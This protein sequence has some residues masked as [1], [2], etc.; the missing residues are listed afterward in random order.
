MAK[1]K[2]TRG[3]K[4]L[5]VLAVLALAAAIVVTVILCIPKKVSKVTDA[6]RD[7]QQSMFLSN[8]D[9]K[10]KFDSFKVKLS[11]TSAQYSLEINNA[12][13]I[14]ALYSKMTSFYNEKLV[15]AEDNKTYQNNY[16]TVLDGF[17]GARKAETEMRSVLKQVSEYTGADPTFVNPAWVRFK[18]KFEV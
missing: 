13:R 4:W 12:S 3:K 16:F 18:E 2:M 1:K 17:D 11:S 8:K 10:A 14:I 15:F 5:I 7:M 6:T 9:D